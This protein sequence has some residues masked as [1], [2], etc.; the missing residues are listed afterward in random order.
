MK[1]FVG[2]GVKTLVPR[3]IGQTVEAQQK[4]SIG[5]PKGKKWDEASFFEDLEKKQGEEEAKV[6][7]EI[8]KWAQQKTTRIWY[9]HG[10]VNGS[11]VPVLKHKDR[12]HQ[13][14]YL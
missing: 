7:R 5:G 3:V 1:Q 11:F 4:K 10:K 13:L 9:G 6:A 2:S 8:F 14:F 12:D